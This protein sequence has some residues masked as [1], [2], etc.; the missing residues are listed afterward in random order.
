[1]TTIDFNEYAREQALKNDHQAMVY[2][3]SGH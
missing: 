2:S 3:A 1:M